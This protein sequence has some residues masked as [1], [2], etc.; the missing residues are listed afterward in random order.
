MSM[1]LPRFD[2]HVEK[3]DG[4]FWAYQQRS[5]GEPVKDPL[6]V[7]LLWIL[8]QLNL[9]YF[10]L[11]RDDRGDVVSLILGRKAVSEQLD[12][13]E[14]EVR[15]RANRRTR[16]ITTAGGVANEREAAT[17]PEYEGLLRRL[18]NVAGDGGYYNTELHY[19]FG[20]VE[21]LRSIRQKALLLD[22]PPVRG[23][24]PEEATWYLRE[25]TRCYLLGLHGACIAL[26]RVCLE[27]CLKVRIPP[28]E[29]ARERRRKKPD[30]KGKGELE[31]LI[32]AALRLGCVDDARA[33]CAHEVRNRGN[34]IMHGRMLKEEESG[35]QLGWTRGLVE[36]L[37]PRVEPTEAH[38]REELKGKHRP[39][40]GQY[41]D[42]LG[43]YNAGPSV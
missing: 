29:L 16:S 1:G 24:A 32:D 41:G 5:A 27:V 20:M 39:R 9:A 42:E 19:A 22:P 11:D 30:G 13:D 36:H 33:F 43:G 38:T 37:F 31:A 35:E 6:H 10:Q 26:C 21:T 23:L 2:G 15:A 12:S 14:S 25:A 17:K 28:S 40:A 34:D 7:T 4:G 8:Q 18:R 3:A